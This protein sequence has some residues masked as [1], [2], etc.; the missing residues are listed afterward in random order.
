[1]TTVIVLSRLRTK[2]L[3]LK[4]EGGK[5]GERGGDMVALG[6]AISGLG[7]LVGVMVGFTVAVAVGVKVASL[8]TVGLGLDQSV[9][10]E[11]VAG[12]WLA[13]PQ[14]LALRCLPL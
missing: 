11:V 10:T 2:S 3:K 13:L 9:L 4:G 8:V 1:M 6:V 7:L 5:G 12:F 14:H